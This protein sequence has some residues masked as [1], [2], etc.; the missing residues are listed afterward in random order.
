[1]EIA[2]WKR[3]VC[4]LEP[5]QEGILFVL[6][7][8]EHALHSVACILVRRNSSSLKCNVLPCAIKNLSCFSSSSRRIFSSVAMRFYGGDFAVLGRGVFR[9]YCTS[10]V[11]ALYHKYQGPP[12]PHVLPLFFSISFSFGSF[13]FVYILNTGMMCTFYSKLITHTLSC[14]ETHAWL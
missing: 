2:V 1:M 14:L 11:R 5:N 7:E 12:P 3:V 8:E 13:F 4:W 6:I 9:C 10:E